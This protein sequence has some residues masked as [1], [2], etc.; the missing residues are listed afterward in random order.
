MGGEVTLPTCSK[1]SMI[2]LL[3]N[4]D[5]KIPN[6]ALKKIEKYHRDRGDDIITDPLDRTF[7]EKI[8]V[9]CIFSKNRHLCDEWE[10]K[11][12]IGG[13][14]YD[15][16]KKLPD[17]IENQKPRINWGFTT[18]GCVRKCSFCVVPQKEGMIHPV[19]DIYD[20]WDGVSKEI[21]L[22]DNNILAA[23]KHL[24]LICSQLRKEKIRVDF[25]QGLD[26]RLLTED[27]MDD[28]K[29]VR[30]KAYRF[31]WD[32][33]DMSLEKKFKRVRERLGQCMNYI[34]AGYEGDD[35][36]IVL[37]KANILKGMGHRVYIMRYETYYE[38]PR[39]VQVARWANQPAQFCKRTFK[40]FLKERNTVLA[41]VV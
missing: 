32:S 17:E 36:D 26:I 23:P 29:S 33:H 28:L 41:G 18:R 19:G 27:M 1:G 38:D 15:I 11:A 37:K 21:T 12:E 2:V 13:T 3:V 35:F 16:Y 8:Y 34:L 9:S 30:H 6:L 31:A 14:G 24:K 7:A 22:M 5:S 39:Y 4:I 10:G 20:I 40:E 25:N